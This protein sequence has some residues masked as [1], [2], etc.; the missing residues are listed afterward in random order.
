MAA[1]LRTMFKSFLRL[2][3]P[4]AIVAAGLA[5]CGSGQ[6]VETK[7]AAH[8]PTSAAPYVIAPDDEIEVIVWKQR[9]VSGKVVVAQDGTITVPLAGQITAAGLTS[10]ELQKE[11]TRRLA[12][13]IDGPNVTV[14]V[15][16]ARSQTV[17]V[18]GE[19]QK[20]GALRLRPGEVL[21][22]ALAEA[23]GF[24][25]FADLSQIRITRRSPTQTEQISVNYN[26][27]QSGRDLSGDVPLV[28]GDV[29]HVP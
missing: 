22:Q 6:S 3:L 15:A 23:G 25:A 21:S 29:V 10:D 4:I 24:T 17:Y 19:V 8:Q 5:G 1:E 27:V 12:A 2:I 9:E 16:D 14:R 13:F 18:A 20:P 7:I 26:L 11:V 28:A